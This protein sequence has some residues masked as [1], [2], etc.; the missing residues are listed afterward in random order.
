[1]LLGQSATPLHFAMC[2]FNPSNDT[3]GNVET[4]GVGASDAGMT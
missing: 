1:V 3:Q 2:T 4:D